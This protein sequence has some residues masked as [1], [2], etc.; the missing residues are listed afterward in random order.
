MIRRDIGASLVVRRRPWVVRRDIGA[1]R[2]MHRIT[3]VMHRITS[4]APPGKP[5]WSTVGASPGASPGRITSDAPSGG[6]SPGASFLREMA[7]HGV[8]CSGHWRITSDAGSNQKPTL[9]VGVCS[10]TVSFVAGILSKRAPFYGRPQFNVPSAPGRRRGRLRTPPPMGGGRPMVGDLP[11]NI[12]DGLGHGFPPKS[13]E[14]GL[15][16]AGQARA[17][18]E[19]AASRIRRK[20]H[21]YSRG[22]QAF[23]GAS[24]LDT[25]VPIVNCSGKGLERYTET[26]PVWRE[27]RFRK[28]EK[29]LEAISEVESLM[30]KQCRSVPG[31]R[32][33]PRTAQ[34]PDFPTAGFNGLIA[35]DDLTPG[36]PPVRLFA[37]ALILSVIAALSVVS[38]SSHLLRLCPLS[39]NKSV[40]VPEVLSLMVPWKAS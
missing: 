1:S 12:R 11:Q 37:Y 40:Y 13:G 3:P 24:K 39:P 26:V 21:M 32:P 4:D 22:Q 35:P 34:N 6:Q 27:G 29:L 20:V 8:M 10:V 36:P 19:Q 16:E 33:C 15:A 38:M 14:M 31:H 17:G 30:V 2:V 23:H 28:V 7:H 9:S 25:S 5:T 18:R